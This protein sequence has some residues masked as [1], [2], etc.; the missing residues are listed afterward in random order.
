MSLLWLSRQF[1]SHCSL[2]YGGRCVYIIVSVAFL[3]NV[4]KFNKFDFSL[5]NDDIDIIKL[6][7]SVFVRMLS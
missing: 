4:S 7:Y 5:E 1:C 2:C 3:S 6:V